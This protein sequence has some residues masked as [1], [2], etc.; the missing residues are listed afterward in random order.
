MNTKI[1]VFSEI[2]QLR[3]VI[4]HRPDEG[5]AR[6]SPKRAE[7]LLFDDIV[8][9]PQMQ[10]E[11]EIFTKVLKHLIGAENVLE[12]EDLLLDALEVDETKKEHIVDLIADYEELPTSL[13]EKLLS[14][15]NS[16][17]KEVLITGYDKQE[18]FIYFDPIPNFI[19]TRD[20]AVVVNDHV[21]ITKAAKEARHRENFLTRFIFW[22]HPLF[23]HL[24][25]EDKIINLNHIDEFPPSRKG[26]TVSIEGGD[27]M[28]LHKDYL[29]VG[30]SERSTAHGIHSL[31][32]KL[33][34]KGVV[35]NVVQINVPKDRS[36][37]H[38]D[39]IFTHVNYNHIV[40][41]KPLVA[42]G[43]SSTVEVFRSNGTAKP[44]A[45]IKEFIE[46]EINSN[47]EFIYSGNG[48]SPY[49]EREQW[50]DG[51]NLV[52]IRPGVAIT[53]DRNPRT[54][55]AFQE[56]G[57]EILHAMEF[58]TKVE[59]GEIQPDELQNTIIT[60]PSSELSRAR[61][62]SHCMTCPIIRDLPL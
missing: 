38:I 4:V 54:E 42:E 20:I 15:P 24:R 57:Y 28:L 61:G 58:L 19:F 47:M 32:D 26:E 36:F 25:E 21:V 39:T 18:D 48:E 41:Y 33:F 5:I 37:M 45:S 2:S 27:M 52:A 11:H 56:A 46:N 53:Y 59:N 35:R 8:Y 43:L 6:V 16:N 14:M 62:G 23:E 17:L 51:C 10:K 29:L 12:T 9:L 7:D 40:A 34:K 13:K 55:I 49:Q 44:Y 30:V 60:L 22:A 50:T 1:Q 3:K 31:K